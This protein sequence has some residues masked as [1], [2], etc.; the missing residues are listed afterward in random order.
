M[1]RAGH[2]IRERLQTPLWLCYT[3]PG[4]ASKGVHLPCFG[5]CPALNVPPTVLISLL[6]IASDQSVLA[7]NIILFQPILQQ[8]H[9][10]VTLRTPGL[11]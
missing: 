9:W 10:L 11:T 3:Q 5:G 8:A 7:R 6:R 1:D 4:T 2:P